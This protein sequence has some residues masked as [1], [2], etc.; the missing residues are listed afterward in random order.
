[1][2]IILDNDIYDEIWNRFKAEF[3]FQP[4]VVNGNKPFRIKQFHKVYKLLKVWDSRDES[5][6]NDL[7]SQMGNS[8][9]YALDWQHDCFIFNPEEK[10]PLHT[11]WHDGIRDV[12]V[13]FP[14]YYPDG[15][16]HIFTDKEFS[17]GILGSPWT[18]EIYV[19]GELLVKLMD[20]KKDVLKL[21][22]V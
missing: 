15:D 10:I 6:I 7:M 19:F 11:E 9:I 20:E 17:Y 12:Q 8:D 4:S 22:Q 18:R 21:Q 3:E 2:Q 14:C 5:L 1:M 16:Y 13:Y